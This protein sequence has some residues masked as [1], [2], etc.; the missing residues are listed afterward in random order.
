MLSLKR[1][2][3]ELSDDLDEIVQFV[4][5]TMIEYNTKKTEDLQRV[6]DSVIHLFDKKE[7]CEH[8]VVTIFQSM[9][10]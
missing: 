4:T 8:V 3:E 5:A 9:K 2:N 1:K 10:Q 6:I 7:E